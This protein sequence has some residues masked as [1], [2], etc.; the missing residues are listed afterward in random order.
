MDASLAFGLG[1]ALHAVHAALELHERVHLVALHL[2]RDF[3]VAAGFG[4]HDVEQLDLPLLLAGEALVHLEQVACEDFRL[5]AARAAADFHDDVLLVGRVDRDEHEFDLFLDA[6][7]LAFDARDFLLSELLH[8]GVGQHL[9]GFG[10][11]VFGLHVGARLLHERPL[12]GVLFGEPVVFFLVGEHVG[13]AHLLLELFVRLDYLHELLAHVLFCHDGSFFNWNEG[14][15]EW[16][17][18]RMARH[19]LS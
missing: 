18:G 3:A 11:V 17:S 15:R 12:V 4:G 19:E 2:E 13:V 16:E 8:V 7:K 10:Q 1:N 5:V 6:G 9:L 14:L